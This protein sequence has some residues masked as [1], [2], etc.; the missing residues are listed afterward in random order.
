MFSVLYIYFYNCFALVSNYNLY[1]I[2]SKHSQKKIPYIVK[3]FMNT[4]LWFMKDLVCT[5]CSL[6]AKKSISKSNSTLDKFV[7]SRFVNSRHFI[8]II[9][10][11]SLVII[12]I[13]I[14]SPHL[15]LNMNVNEHC[16]RMLW[17]WYGIYIWQHITHNPSNTTHNTH[18][19]Q[20]NT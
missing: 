11:M 4:R 15:N 20:H 2:V 12:K 16:M 17:L 5:L 6:V 14:L 7:C 19:I 3:S 1:L 9:K 13:L 18:T 8:F 10:V